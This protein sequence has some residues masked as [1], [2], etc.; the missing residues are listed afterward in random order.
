[1]DPNA[2]LEEQRY[3]RNNL[4]RGTTRV[5][6]LREAAER[7]AHLTEELDIWIKNGGFLPRDWQKQPDSPLV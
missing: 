3:L 4:L 1:M 6:E 5:H 7:L 2:N